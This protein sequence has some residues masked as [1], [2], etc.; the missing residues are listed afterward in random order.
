MTRRASTPARQAA[1]PTA[2][3]PSAMSSRAWTWSGKSSKSPVSATKGA[4]IMKGQ[5]LDPE[6]KIVKAVQVK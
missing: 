2:S 3:P 4:G 6:I 1:T 5:M